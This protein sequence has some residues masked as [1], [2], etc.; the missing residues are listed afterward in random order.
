MQILTAPNKVLITK[1]SKVKKIGYATKKLV[2]DMIICL[3]AQDDPQGIGLAAPQVGKGLRLFII[4]PSPTSDLQVFI[5]PK[6]IK[7]FDEKK[8]EKKHKGKKKLEGCLSIPR[9]WAPINRKYGIDLEYRDLDGKKIN[10]KF[11]GYKSI[12]LQ[13]E[14]DHLNGIMFTQRALEQKVQLYEEKGDKLVKITT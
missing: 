14:I 7:L 11:T 12:I 4:K 10:Q 1:A 9:I 2:R 3:E 8:G 5:N 6:V 13:H